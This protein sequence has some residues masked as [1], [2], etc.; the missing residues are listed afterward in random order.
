MNNE[1]NINFVQNIN[2][3]KKYQDWSYIYLGRNETPQLLY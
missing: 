2:C 1:W 3:I